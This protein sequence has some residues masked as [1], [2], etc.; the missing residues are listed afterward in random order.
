M[1]QSTEGRSH[2]TQRQLGECLLAE[3]LI[4]PQQLEQAIEHQSIY[5]GRLGTSLIELQLVDEQD[6]ARVLSQQLR[7]HFIKP[8]RLMHVPAR[9]LALIPKKTALQYQVVPYHTNGKRLYVAI[10]ES[11][12]LTQLDELSFQLDHIL[13][14]LAI[15]EIRLKMALHKHYGMSLSPRQKALAGQLDRGFRVTAEPGGEHLFPDP[16]GETPAHTM[17]VSDENRS[18]RPEDS[19]SW[20]LLGEVE[21]SGDPGIDDV[22]VERNRPV[23]SADPLT[24][25]LG[26]LARAVDRDQLAEALIAYLEKIFPECALLM[27]RS[28]T[29]SGWRIA[30]AKHQQLFSRLVI[31]G[32]EASLF[33]PLIDRH[34]P[35]RGPFTDCPANRRLLA[36]FNSPVPELALALP[37]MIRSR[38]VGILYVQGDAERLEQYREELTY[39]AAKLEMALTHLILRNKILNV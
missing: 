19:D 28:G 1:H 34:Q 22:Y 6:M 10:N 14:P 30:S 9:V 5:G 31:A 26:E 36:C 3:Q 24:Q 17:E 4:T 11:A 8:Q 16:S 13:I 20:P 29:I 38:L 25:L 33:G 27:V 35:Y 2:H 39:L 15:P 18:A 7:L 12:N 23:G 37:L 32:H 21:L